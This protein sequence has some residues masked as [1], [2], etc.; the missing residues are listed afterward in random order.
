MIGG[1]KFRERNRYVIAAVSAV[2]L[3]LAAFVAVDFSNLPLISNQRTYQAYFSSAVGLQTGD[4]VTIAG[5]RVG[6]VS[7]LS[8]HGNKVLVSFTVKGG[9]RLGRQTVVEEKII[10]PV[11][12]Q[13]LEVVPKGRGQL[14]GPI[15]LSRTTV[16]LT[17][18]E[19]LNQLTEQTEQTNLAQVVKS[20]QVSSQVLA[21]TSPQQTRAALEG[22]AALSKVLV[23]RQQEVTQLI[24]QASSLVGLLNQHSAQLVDLIGQSNLVLQ[25][26]DERRAALTQLLQT[27]DQLSNQLD[28]ILVADKAQLDPLL[29]NLEGVSQVLAKDSGDLQRAIPLLA[30]FDR[31]IANAT[32]S[33]PY[34]D[35]VAPTLVLPD[36]LIAQCA[37][38]PINSTT[39]CRP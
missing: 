14:S 36:N 8:L 37:R 24:G 33:G 15:P 11:G 20:L 17:L 32:G 4:V 1:L 39:G 3:A 30:A 35:F 25:V 9:W 38:L 13:Y 10:N 12:V 5:V 19:G 26:L 16:P 29:T 34:T 22:V 7:G 2:V 18:I 6:S 31:Y 28:H 27:T 21:G 23:A